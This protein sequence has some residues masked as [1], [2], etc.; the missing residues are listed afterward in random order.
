MKG[1]RHRHEARAAPKWSKGRAEMELDY[2]RWANS[3]THTKNTVFFKCWSFSLFFIPCWGFRAFQGHPND[4][5]K[6]SWI[7]S[8]RSDFT[9][10]QKLNIYTFLKFPGS[11]RDPQI[12]RFCPWP[13]RNTVFVCCDFT[14][15]PDHISSEPKPRKKFWQLSQQDFPTIFPTHT[16]RSQYFPTTLFDVNNS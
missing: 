6:S 12:L 13:P 8:G 16:C 9:R 1:A 2:Q 3:A 15:F 14:I 11:L 10:H 4:H 7:V 5:A